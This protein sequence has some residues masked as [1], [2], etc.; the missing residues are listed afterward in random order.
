MFFDDWSSALRI[1][2]WS[3]VILVVSL[4]PGFQHSVFG[5]GSGDL[6]FGSWSYVPSTYLPGFMFLV[7]CFLVF[8]VWC[9]VY[10][11]CKVVW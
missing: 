6:A 3:S 2:I 4:V 10:E 8:G 1:L 5:F 9:H 7:L 11:L